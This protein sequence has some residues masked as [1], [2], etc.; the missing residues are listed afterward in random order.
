MNVVPRAFLSNSSRLLTLLIGC[1]LLTGCAN[2]PVSGFEPYTPIDISDKFGA[3]GSRLKI[4]NFYVV[5]DSSSSMSKEY[6]GG[7]FTKS[8][9]P[10]RFEV[11][12]E[13]L[14]RINRTIPS[15]LNFD[16]TLR[17]FGSLSCTDGQYSLLRYGPGPYERTAFEQA[18]ET[19]K[20]ASGIT[21]MG[22]AINAAAADLASAQGN[23]GVLVLSDGWEP[24]D[25][26]IDQA[27][28]LKEK[29]GDRLCLYT[30]SLGEDEDSQALMDQL[31]KSSG[32]GL[33]VTAAELASTAA[34]ADL[35]TAIFLGEVGDEDADGVLD[36][37]DKCPGTPRG[38]RVNAVG[39]WVGGTVLFDFDKSDIRPDAHPFLDEVVTILSRETQLRVE[40][41][42]HTDNIGSAQ[43][44]LDL[45]RRRA[46]AVKKY[47]VSHGIASERLTTQGYGF[48]DPVASND[49]ELGRAENRRVQF[50]KAD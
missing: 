22:E 33:S 48:S 45:S 12:K 7:G 36:P 32:C 25:D 19:V 43:Y 15:S 4:K 5:L 41:Q 47:L 9:A 14:S 13:V 49:T 38:A 8:P 26:P 23:I 35:V 46:D 40:V 37:D 20:C 44:N 6:R 39:C 10:S 34:V 2:A 29:F 1:L 31:A 27:S 3:K 42:G 21:P 16:A 11:E 17:T 24:D 28:R 30:V 18:M 50:K